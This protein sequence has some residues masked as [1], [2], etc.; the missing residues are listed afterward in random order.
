[1][2]TVKALVKDNL[3]N[4][5]KGNIRFFLNGKRKTNFAYNRATDRLI[6]TARKLFF[7]RHTV[8]ITTRDDAGNATTKTWS[9]T[10]KK[11]R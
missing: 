9:F 3:T 1:M 2:D 10:V 11:S 5:L 8:R 4:L 7:K 6:F